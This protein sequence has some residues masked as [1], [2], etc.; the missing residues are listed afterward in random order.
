MKDGIE[1]HRRYAQLFQ[2]GDFF[3]DSLKV[4]AV[5]IE[6]MP[7]LIGQRRGIPVFHADGRMPV[8]AVFAGLDVAAWVAV[9]ETVRENLIEN[10]LFYPF[11]LDIVRQE[12]KIVGVVR[13][14]GSDFLLVIEIHRVIADQ[15]EMILHPVFT[16]FQRRFVIHQPPLLFDNAHFL[17]LLRAIGNGAQKHMPHRRVLIHPEPDGSRLKQF[18]SRIAYK[19]S[20]PVAVY[21]L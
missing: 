21:A 2:I 9:A 13:D 8:L 3:H 18:G 14:I 10:R 16:H 12:H 6:A 1:I 11:R 7:L 4:S 15:I 5:E 20:R 17:Q 19:H